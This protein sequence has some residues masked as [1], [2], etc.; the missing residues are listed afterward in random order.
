MRLLEPARIASMELKNSVFMAPMGTTT[1]EDGSFSE[2][3]I[4]YYEERAIG[5][6]GL[7]ITGANQVTTAY[8]QKACNIIGSERSMVQARDLA[9]RA[10]S[11][12]PRNT[13]T[14]GSCGDRVV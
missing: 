1:E 14:L 3:S 13:L 2:R 9:D 5:G 10:G 12:D 11:S 8:E 6:F 4:R 7:I